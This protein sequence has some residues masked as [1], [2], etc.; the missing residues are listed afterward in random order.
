MSQ[1]KPNPWP[2]EKALA[3]VAREILYW[4]ARW[5]GKTFWWQ[6]RLLYEIEKPE[7]R[8][9]VLRHTYKDLLERIDNATNLYKP[10][11]AK[12]VGNPATITFPSWA[13]IRTWHLKDSKSFEQYKWHQYDKILIE[14]LT[15]IPSEDLYEKLLWSLRS[16]S[17][18]QKQVFCTTNPDWVGRLRVKRR[19]V[20]IT[21][22]WEIYTDD[23]W[24]TRIFIPARV[25]DNPKLQEADPMYEKQ[26]MSIKDDQLR[27]AWLEWDREAYDVKWWIY[28]S[29][30]KQ[31]RD[32]NR[33]TT[34]PYEKWLP[35]NTAR[36]L[37]ISDAMTIWF[38]QKVW[39]EIRIID[40]YS[41]QWE[42]FGFYAD[43]L[44]QRWYTYWQHYAPHDISVRELGTGKSRLD[45]A[46]EYWINFSQVP[47]V[48]IRDW[49]NTARKTFAYCYFDR[50]KCKTSLEHLEVYRKERD[51]K[52]QVFKNK[53]YHWPESHFADAFRYMCLSVEDEI[54]GS[55]VET[56][57]FSHL[58]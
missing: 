29:Q 37:G 28:T 58:V 12:V 43:V 39:K 56:T 49:I 15:L 30:I 10:L 57:D 11:G 4:W 31:A 27:K 53:P 52:H 33:V 51:D 42:W 9:L 26:L 17:D 18:I 47:N 54:I 14:E 32:E 3:S 40:S 2:Q 36:D 16:T 21:E 24:L 5:W 13:R 19:F 38:Y 44:N 22:P 34:V 7:Y 45:Q 48:W 41:N 8:A 6:L 35:V 50:I 20:D 46:R 55:T 25:S 23:N 1:I